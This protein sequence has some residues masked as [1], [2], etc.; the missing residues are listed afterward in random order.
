MNTYYEASTKNMLKIGSGTN[1]GNR[2]LLRL[3][4]PE[5]GK[6]CPIQEEAFGILKDGANK[7]SRVGM[8]KRTAFTITSN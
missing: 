8:L 3:F 2:A 7:K 1:V 6:L 4:E 5:K